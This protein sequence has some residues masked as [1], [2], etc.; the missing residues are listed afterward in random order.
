MFQKFV[1]TVIV[2]IAS[3]QLNLAA[4]V[5]N[6]CSTDCGIPDHSDIDKLEGAYCREVAGTPGALYPDCCPKLSCVA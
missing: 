2:F 3:L 1:L 6:R 5:D 4:V